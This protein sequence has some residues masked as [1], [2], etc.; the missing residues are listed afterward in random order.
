MEVSYPTRVKLAI[1]FIVFVILTSTLRQLS[2]TLSSFRASPQIDDI[3]QYE[4][5]FAE[6]KYFLPP[7]QIISYSD[8]FAKF[9][10]QCKA[11]VLAQYSLAPT[12]LHAL[13]SDCGRISGTGSVSSEMSRLILDNSHDSGREPDLLRLFPNAYFQPQDSQDSVAGDYRVAANQTVL[14]KDFGLGVR[15]YTRGGK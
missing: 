13:D 4:R 5:R 3:T 12:V 9:S 1:A 10:G 7:N 11:F 15:L 8:E 6:V 2:S 14:L